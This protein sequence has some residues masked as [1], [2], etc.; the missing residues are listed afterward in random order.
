MKSDFNSLILQTQRFV[1]EAFK[2]HP[3][4]SFNDWRVMAEHSGTVKDLALEIAETLECNKKV[5]AISALLHDIGKT[6]PADHDTLHTEH[7]SFNWQVSEEFLKNLDLSPEELDQIK[8]LIL[9]ESEAVEMKIIKDADALAF[10]KDKRLY[11]LFINW[12][13]DN[14]LDWAIQRKID[15]YHKLN[16][17]ISRQLG[18]AWWQQMQDDWQAFNIQLH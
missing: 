12:A 9:F 13:K 4:F 5:L 8:S 18:E 2:Q 15:K 6:Y 16:F 11:M 17:E 14:N 1:D 10:F 3:D 7:E